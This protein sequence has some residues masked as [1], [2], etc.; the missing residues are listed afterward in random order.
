MTMTEL[1][2]ASSSSAID[3]LVERLFAA[4]STPWKWRVHLGGRPGFSLPLGE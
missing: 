1:A 2:E 4:V 3:A